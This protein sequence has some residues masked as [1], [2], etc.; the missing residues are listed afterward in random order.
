LPE[1]RANAQ[2]KEGLCVECGDQPADLQ[3]KQCEDIFCEVC[4]LSQHKRGNRQRHTTAPLKQA[5][6]QAQ[7]VS[8]QVSAVAADVD[9]SDSVNIPVSISTAGMGSESF[10]ERAKWIPL[11]LTLED[12]KV[13]RLLEATM[14]VSEY[15]DKIDIYSAEQKSKRI[16][17]Q[18]REVCAI[19]SGLVIAQDF[20]KGQQLI[21]DKEFSEIAPYFRF[22]FELGRR[23]KIRNPE[24]M[25]GAYGKLMY[26]LQDSQIPEI[27]ELLEFSMVSPIHTVHSRL[28]QAGALALLQ[29][30]T[31]QL[32][33]GT[34][35]AE[36]KTRPQIDREIK[37]KERA[38]EQLARKY[39]CAA[40]PYE[41]V[42]TCILSIGDA[43]SYLFYN[44]DPVIKMIEL[45]KTHF[46]PDS[47]APGHSLAILSG[48][49]GA[50]LTHSHQHQY[51]YCLQ[52]MTLWRTILHNMYKLWMLT[53]AD[54]LDPNNRYRLVNTGQGLNR[55]QSCP[56][57]GRAMSNILHGTQQELGSW[58][59]SSV[60]HLGDSN[61]PNSL[62]FIDKYNQVSRILQPIVICIR[63]LDEIYEQEEV[64]VF[65][66]HA[67]GGREQCKR[68]ILCDFFRHAFDGSGSDNFF[69]AGSCIDGR[70]TSAWNWCQNLDKKKSIYSVF[71]LTGFVGFDGDWS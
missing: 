7:A 5:A 3:C 16:M 67:F 51:E 66:D 2:S 30:D 45:L 19:L 8:H 68:A 40:L 41:E 18:L 36:G 71:L 38:L 9:M 60:I 33:T 64:K 4:F 65:V 23:H 43:N 37:T 14:N 15:T 62:M 31:L 54:L 58:I 56:N 52:S 32:A 20:P 35:L 10:V 26:L 53:E 48:V 39:E 44:R 34:I 46:S 57:V 6:R 55:M 24:K 13:M 22:V 29:E 69:E 49:G 12:R 70:L 17:A 47:F 28:Q 63:R 25:R 42:R 1:S 61:V 27:Q 11:R 59:G 21:K 50:R